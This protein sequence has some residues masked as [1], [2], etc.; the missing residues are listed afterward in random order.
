M[1]DSK[2]RNPALPAAILA[3]AGFAATIIPY[4]PESIR[5]LAAVAGLFFCTGYA[6]IR[7][8]GLFRGWERESAAALAFPV[9][10]LL[11]FLPLFIGQLSGTGTRLLEWVARP[12]LIV[13]AVLLFREAATARPRFSLPGRLLFLCGVLMAVALW[14]GAL[15]T[16][17]SDAPDHIAVIREI[18][19]SG[20]NFPTTSYY[21]RST[22]ENLDARKG[23]YHPVTA[24]AG[25][26]TRVDAVSVY[27][28]IPAL[29]VLLFTLA[30]YALARETLGGRIASAIALLLALLSVKGGIF[31]TW[32]GR[33]ATPFGF[34]VPVIWCAF[35]LLVRAAR[36]KR[37]V[38]LAELVIGFA[39][40]GIHLFAVVVTASMGGFF[41]L[42]FLYL[43]RDRFRYKGV[44]RS[45]FLIGAGCLPIGIWRF[46]HTYPALDP[47]HTHL[48][49]VVLFGNGFFCSNPLHAYSWV[50][51]SALLAIPLCL[52]L[53]RK[54]RE[55][56]GIL[57]AV[58]VTLLPPLIILNPVIVP[59]IAS[60]IGYLVG[61]ITW[62]GGYYLVLGALSAR[63]IEAV[64]RPKRAH[65]RVFALAALAALLLV[66]VSSLWV[67]DA[68]DYRNRL[69]LKPQIL[70]DGTDPEKWSDLIQFMNREL[71]DRAIVATDPFTGYMVPAFTTQK[72]ISIRE[73][74]SSTGDPEAPRRLKDMVRVMSP[75]FSGRETLHILKQHGADYVLLNFR[76]P[77]IIT[78]HFST[79]DPGL[80]LA[81]LEKFRSEPERYDEVYARDRC[82][83]FRIVKD[84]PGYG[85]EDP[86][87]SI[88][89]ETVP[90]E[91]RRV[92]YLFENGV[93]LLGASI[94]PDR[95]G[96]CESLE[97]ACF[98]KKEKEH[99]D[100]LPYK[101][102]LRLD[103]MGCENSGGSGMKWRRI[104]KQIRTGKK[105]RA[106][107]V[108][109]AGGGTY[110]IFAWSVGE[111][112]ADTIRYRLPEN[113]E[114]GSYE[115]QILLRR[116]SRIPVLHISDFI[117]EEDSYRGVPVGE[118]VVAAAGKESAAVAPF[119]S[120]GGG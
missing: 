7:V 63:W 119:I 52:L 48:Q 85:R 92:D 90:P 4:G 16:M 39:L 62:L 25:K 77:G 2:G 17:E 82:H 68:I 71:P 43:K 67:R 116:S 11:L 10:C 35:L 99:R 31:G 89:V 60:V 3:L 93:R 76:F 38:L 101:V 108:R 118:L 114:E 83:L 50:S 98:W 73:Q 51:S 47:I 72:T 22:D 79:V 32:F 61:R 95:L 14:K 44:L 105:S 81:T 28:A 1:A 110:P 113:L 34:S 75:Y 69:T 55:D 21:A 112:V 13:A 111:T 42:S 86:V 5:I 74:H 117:S 54:A 87:L 19:R 88:R 6:L 20:E 15:I 56:V 91:A 57:F 12:Y 109:N 58:S 8:T 120:R 100:P 97:I 24:V 64:V 80:Y 65:G 40:A 84:A 9:S 94:M 102:C 107:S 37:A 18:E 66:V 29:A 46:I 103:K 53:L 27:D 45:L 59:V 30:F 41:L 78:T 115:L 70:S 106:R 26:L 96:V 36:G 104:W 33:S 49:G 23:Y